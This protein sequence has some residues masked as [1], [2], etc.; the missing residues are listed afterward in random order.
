M[1]EKFGETLQVY[2]PAGTKE[3]LTKVAAKRYQ[4]PT[5][6]ARVAIMV[7]LEKAMREEFKPA[8]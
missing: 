8:A 4:T 5:A 1:A 3:Q 7:E 2:L 6:L